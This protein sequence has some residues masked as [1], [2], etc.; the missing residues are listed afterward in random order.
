MPSLRVGGVSM[1]KRHWGKRKRTVAIE[2]G[3][4]LWGDVR[5]QKR[6]VHGFLQGWSGTR[7]ISTEDL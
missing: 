4:D 6:F 7:R 2:P 3:T 5:Q 1:M